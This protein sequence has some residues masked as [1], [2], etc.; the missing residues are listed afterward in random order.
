M[1]DLIRRD[2]I[3]WNP[4]KENNEYL[5]VLFGQNFHLQVGSPEG[6]GGARV[7]VSSVN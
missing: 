6:E 4:K 5:F 1:T 3:Y 7:W 2:R